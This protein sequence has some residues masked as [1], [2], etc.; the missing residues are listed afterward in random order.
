MTAKLSIQSS[1]G[2]CRTKK[3]LNSS[4]KM[5]LAA[6]FLQ[7][8]LLVSTFCSASQVTEI[9]DLKGVP[10]WNSA[11][12]SL[13]IDLASTAVESKV[14]SENCRHKFI[15]I[16]ESIKLKK[17]WAVKREFNLN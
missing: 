16:I 1:C 15:L 6:S 2:H 4:K 10:K 14:I 17:L 8:V 3:L 7:S 11:A 13:I 9:V 5:K 12:N